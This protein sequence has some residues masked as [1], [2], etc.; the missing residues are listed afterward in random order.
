MWRE[1]PALPES[2]LSI[3][4]RVLLCVAHPYMT[5]ERHEQLTMLLTS[6]LDWDQVVALAERHEVVPLLSRHL[7]A[8]SAETV[9]DAVRA[10]LAVRMRENL[11]R[12]LHLQQELLRVLTALNDAALP[13]MPLKGPWLG[14]LLY[15]DVTLRTTGDLDLLVQ[16]HDL[17]SAEQVLQDLGYTRGRPREHEEESYHYTFVYDDR[18]TRPVFV[19]LHWDI[20][21][22]H[23]ARHDMENVWRAAARSEWHGREIWTMAA[24]DLFLIL[25]QNAA[26][27]TFGFLKQLVDVALVIERYGATW[28][29]AVLAHTIRTAQ[30]RTRVYL[31]VFLVQR[32]LGGQIPADFLEAI[33]PPQGI[34]WHVGQHLF[35]RRGGVLHTARADVGPPLNPLLTLLWEDSLRGKLRHLRRLVF[36]PASYQARWTGQSSSTS[37]WWWYPLWIGQALRYAFRFFLRCV[38]NTR[39]KHKPVEQQE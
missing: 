3:E 34:S 4:D 38:I 10:T 30:M 9:P 28:S 29:W 18:R 35:R 2:W 14:E 17:D 6:P 33:H 8:V 31:T 32:L 11:V 39:N 16:P 21:R 22:A 1:R 23:I 26:K 36:P 12:N 24:P 5:P 15:G 27:D 19:E 13:V 20:V 7:H 25:C 37:L